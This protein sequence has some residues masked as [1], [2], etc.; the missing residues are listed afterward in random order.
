[1]T[2]YSSTSSAFVKIATIGTLLVLTLVVLSLVTT[3]H[4][5]GLFG[6]AVLALIILGA[7]LYFIQIP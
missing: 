4:I 6:G 2:S 5:Y 1:M 7:V 3:N